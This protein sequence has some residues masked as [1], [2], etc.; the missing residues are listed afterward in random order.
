MNI[1]EQQNIVCNNEAFIKGTYNGI[2][3]IIRKKDGYINAT[4]M[5]EQ[6]NKRFRKIFENH[7]WQAFYNEFLIEYCVS[8]EMGE[9][10]YELKKG[11]TNEIRGTYVDSKLINYIAFWAS[12]KYAIIVSKIMD[13]INEIGQ[14]KQLSFEEN[15][16]EIIDL[17]NKEI[18]ELKNKNKELQEHIKET[19]VPIDNCDKDLY[20]IVE[21]ERLII[22][23]NSSKPPEFF[24]YHFTFPA[25]INI[26]QLLRE[27]FGVL[28]KLKADRLSE[29]IEYINGF[30]PK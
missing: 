19:S 5:C 8:P 29:V 15:T 11:Y 12:P 17:L 1:V 16:N 24:D 9:P 26:K 22:S 3:V 21:G 28:K 4:K 7:A 18:T 2:N 14:L 25:S 30:E 10:I 23:A 6:F 13:K 20:L 27:E